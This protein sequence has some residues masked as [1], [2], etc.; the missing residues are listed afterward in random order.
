MSGTIGHF[1][2]RCNLGWALKYTTSGLW[3]DVPHPWFDFENDPVNP[4]TYILPDRWIR[5]AQKFST[6]FGSVPEELQSL[7]GPLDCPSA[8]LFHD[9]AFDN[10]GWWESNDQGAT[11][12]YVSKTMAEV[13]D[14][15]FDMAEAE[16]VDWLEREEMFSGVEVGGTAL[17]NNHKGPFPVDPAPKGNAS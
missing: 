11:W 13:N 7:V 1:T 17:W 9:S 4:L 10:H 6:D 15:L 5:P 3:G 16:G 14:M 8:Y 12:Q 2:G